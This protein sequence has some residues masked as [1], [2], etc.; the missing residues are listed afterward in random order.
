MKYY[1]YIII[2]TLGFISCNPESKKQDFS[3]KLKTIESPKAPET[4]YGIEIND[5]SVETMLVKKNQ[6]IGDI[7]SEEGIDYKWVL[8]ASDL[9]SIFDIRKIKTGQN[10]TFFRTQKRQ[11]CQNRLLSL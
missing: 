9:D 8:K 11:S 10:I 2:A 5:Y 4:K 3:K 7:F 1:I 6:T